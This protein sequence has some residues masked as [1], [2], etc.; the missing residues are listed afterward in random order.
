MPT[1]KLP[2]LRRLRRRPQHAA[3]RHTRTVDTIRAELAAEQDA[4][5]GKHAAVIDPPTMRMH[6]IDARR[7]VGMAGPRWAN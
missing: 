1:L 4:S 5:R 7:R 6:S 2:K 3:G